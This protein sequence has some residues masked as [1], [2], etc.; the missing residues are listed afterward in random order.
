MTKEQIAELYKS[1]KTTDYDGI[2]KQ[3]MSKMQ[4]E[5]IIQF[6]GCMF[7]KNY[8]GESKIIRLCS[9]THDV[10]SQKRISDF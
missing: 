8:T 9:E 7:S 1:R 10:D 6:L 3:L 5:K 2:V 4:D